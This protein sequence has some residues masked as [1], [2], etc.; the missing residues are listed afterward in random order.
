MLFSR[1]LKTPR[2]YCKLQPRACFLQLELPNLS[3]S[4]QKIS[5]NAHFTCFSCAFQSKTCLYL[6]KF[7][8]LLNSIWRKLQPKLCHTSIPSLKLFKIYNLKCCAWHRVL[9]SKTHFHKPLPHAWKLHRSSSLGGASGTQK[10][11]II[12]STLAGIWTPICG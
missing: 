1:R 12:S 3:V 10:S 5:K 4:P 11:K 6:Q 9:Q 8:D 7:N 2:F